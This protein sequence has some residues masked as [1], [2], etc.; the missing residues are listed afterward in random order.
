MALAARLSESKAGDVRSAV[1]R[2]LSLHVPAHSSAGTSAALVHDLSE[3]G[4][5]IEAAATF[6]VNEIIRVD[7]P[8]AG[9]VEAK[10]VWVGNG[11]AG[12]RFLDPVPKAAVSA[13]L[14]RSPA[15]TS[16][17]RAPEQPELPMIGV[18]HEPPAEREFLETDVEPR[19]SSGALALIALLLGLFGTAIFILSLLWMALSD[20]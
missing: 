9:I 2:T 19:R 14:L 10:I 4:L 18:V 7:L 11:F 16:A 20:Q 6:L 13:A 8:E 5:R 1:R 12:C 15:E 17:P 3:H